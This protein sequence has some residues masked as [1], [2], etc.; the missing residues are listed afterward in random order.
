MESPSKARYQKLIQMMDAFVTGEG[1]SRNFVRKME[2]EFAACGLD[3]EDQF[4]DLQLALAMFG[5][6]DSEADGKIL[7]GECRLALRHLREE[8]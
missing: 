6:G 5:A 3:D 7:A 2:G 1:R 8:S 4:R